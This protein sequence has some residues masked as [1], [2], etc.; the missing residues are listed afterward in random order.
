MFRELMKIACV[1]SKMR[2]EGGT[3]MDTSVEIRIHLKK[4]IPRGN[5]FRA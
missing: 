4:L 3:M 1:L 5:R 2:S